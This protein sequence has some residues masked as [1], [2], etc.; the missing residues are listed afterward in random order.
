MGV[1]FAVDALSFA[2]SAATLVLM[3]PL[4]ALGAGAGDHPL[5]AVAAGLRF[6]LVAPGL[7]LDAR[8]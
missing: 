2:V 6:T 1:A 7:P 3:P 4:P 8:A 5:A